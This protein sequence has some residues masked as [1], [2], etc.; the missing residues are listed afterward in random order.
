MYILALNGSPSK[1]GNTAYLL[2][3]IL[4]HCDGAE[5]EIINIPEVIA[6]AKWPFCISCSNPCDKKCYS[7]TRLEEVFDKVT[8]ADFV[9]FG[10]PVYF[11]SMTAQ[12]K[13]FFDKT[14]AVRGEKLWLGKPMC[15]VSVGASLFGGEERT[16]EH[17]Q[18]CA[19]VLGMTVVGNGSEIGMGHFGVSA[20]RPAEND[21]NAVKQCES[22]AKTI[23]TYA[24]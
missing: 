8:K 21:K 15:A 11:G 20:C 3:E 4:S 5:S 10:S 1:D 17:I 2:R 22:M 9:I 24:K 14:R 23:M 13:A 7:G 19:M 16:I 12:L 6:S 18:S